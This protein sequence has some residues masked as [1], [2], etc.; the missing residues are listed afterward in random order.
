MDFQ[1][2]IDCIELNRYQT[3]ADYILKL[4]LGDKYHNLEEMEKVKGKARIAGLIQKNHDSVR[5]RYEGIDNKEI[6]R[7][8]LNDTIMELD[9]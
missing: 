3:A 5:Q 2:V 1:D 4:Q 8:V 6:A 7:R 9:F